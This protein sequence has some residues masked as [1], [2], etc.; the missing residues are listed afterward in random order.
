LLRQIFSNSPILCYFLSC[1]YFN[2]QARLSSLP[3]ILCLP[4]VYIKKDYPLSKKIYPFYHSVI[5]Y[6]SQAAFNSHFSF[7]YHTYYR[8]KRCI[9]LKKEPLCTLD[10]NLGCIIKCV[11]DGYLAK[12]PSW[13]HTYNLIFRNTKRFF[14]LFLKKSNDSVR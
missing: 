2:G 3:Q 6:C 1:Q 13:L 9:F 14:G 5:L 12:N 11:E 10:D 7:I 8:N 4:T